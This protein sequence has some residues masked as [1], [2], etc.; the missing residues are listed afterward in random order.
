MVDGRLSLVP[1][2]G[3]IIPLL[4]RLA[5]GAAVVSRYLLIVLTVNTVADYDDPCWSVPSLALSGWFPCCQRRERRYY[6]I[7]SK[8]NACGDDKSLSS[9]LVLRLQALCPPTITQET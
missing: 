3:T 8:S 7:V 4:I 1:L 9:G 6:V 5:A 2:V